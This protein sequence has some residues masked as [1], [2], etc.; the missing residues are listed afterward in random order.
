VHVALR[1]RSLGVG[2][3]DGLDLA[4]RAGITFVELDWV[5]V[6]RQLLDQAG[7]VRVL[8]ALLRDHNLQIRA[9]YAGSLC[10]HR[11]DQ[12]RLQTWRLRAIMERIKVVGCDLCVVT[13]GARTVESFNTLSQGLAELAA[14][15]QTLGVTVVLANKVDTRAEDRRDLAALFLDNMLTGV[16]LCLDTYNFHLAEV[17]PADLTVEHG[18]RIR[19]VRVSDALGMAAAP[20]GMGEI[21]LARLVNALEG[22]DYDGLLVIDHLPSR[23]RNLIVSELR[24]AREYLEALLT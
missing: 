17:D 15:G 24:R 10:A 3:A 9:V 23:G 12:L 11:A 4:A 8:Q 19:S 18:G 2:I 14:I 16:G 20:F 7:G 6:Q 5:P 22:V 13:A 21:D 1:V